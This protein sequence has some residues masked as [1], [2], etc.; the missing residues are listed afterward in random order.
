MILVVYQN[1][2]DINT[3]EKVV[4]TDMAVKDVFKKLIKLRQRIK[5]ELVL[6]I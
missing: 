1:F 2:P 5:M 4:I 3:D 6:K